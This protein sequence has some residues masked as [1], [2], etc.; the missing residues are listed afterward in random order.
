MI[1]NLFEKSLEEI[2]KIPDLEPIILPHLHIS[3]VK[4]AFIKTP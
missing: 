3:A 1:I 2:G 4:E